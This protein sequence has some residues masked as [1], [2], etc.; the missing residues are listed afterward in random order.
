[1]G[2]SV[3]RSLPTTDADDELVVLT[4]LMEEIESNRINKK[5]KYS[6]DEPRDFD[7][8]FSCF[9]TE[10]NNHVG[11]LCDYKIAVSVA[12]AV[13][14]NGGLIISILQ[15]QIRYRRIGV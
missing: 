9:K 13:S 7:I 15:D 4:V 6:A 11:Y 1:M 12:H 8:A 3:G 14:T 5:G 10:I 2:K